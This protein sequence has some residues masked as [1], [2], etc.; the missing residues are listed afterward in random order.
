MCLP[1]ESFL[2]V[3]LL[4]FVISGLPRWGSL[5]LS[6]PCLSSSHE[7]A[8]VVLFFL[9][10]PHLLK[11]WPCVAFPLTFDFFPCKFLLLVRSHQAEI[12][13]VKRLSQGRNNVTRARVEPRSCNQGRCKN[14]ATLLI[15]EFLRNLLQNQKN[16][17][18]E[19]FLKHAII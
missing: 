19:C 18:F 14:E 2:L 17:E 10:N 12:I 4:S 13:I 5:L 11:S 1:V 8:T 9:T 15:S 16:K 7:E 6:D 3:L